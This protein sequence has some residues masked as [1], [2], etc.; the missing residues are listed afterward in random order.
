MAIPW[1]EVRRAYCEGQDTITAICKQF[2]LSTTTFYRRR[3]VEKWVRQGAVQRATPM[4]DNHAMKH[5][6]A[7]SLQEQIA[8]QPRPELLDASERER[9]AR[10]LSSL[11]RT[12]E[13]LQDLDKGEEPDDDEPFPRDLATLREELAE[14]LERLR[15]STGSEP[16]KDCGAA[17]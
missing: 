14:R 12:L 4:L 11:V 16:D 5:R 10:T 17:S 9:A 6:L 15:Q 13:K 3:L 1:D 2:G 7:K 8:S